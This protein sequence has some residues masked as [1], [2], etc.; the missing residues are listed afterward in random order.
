MCGHDGGVYD[1]NLVL[2][3]IKVFVSDDSVSAQKMKKVG[4]LIDKYL[5]EVSPDQNMKVSKFL[6]VAESFTRFCKRL[7]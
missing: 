4:G 5:G 3:L 2:R 1:V 7:F 6:G